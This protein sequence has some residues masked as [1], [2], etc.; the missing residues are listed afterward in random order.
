M[1]NFF[2]AVGGTGQNVALAYYRMTTLCGYE[3]S[4]I[5]VMDSDLSISTQ[6]PSFIPLEPIPVEPCILPLQRNSFRDLFNPTGDTVIDSVMSILFTSKEMRIPI[7]EGMF[8]RPS[9]GATTI[10]DK[11]LLMENDNT[12]KK[13]CQRSDA[14]LAN[15]LSTLQTEGDHSVV[16]C[17]S[18]MGGTGA[19][20]VPT[21]AQYIAR[22]VDKTKVKI[23]VLYSLRHFNILLP[24]QQ[25][26]YDEIKN[27]QLK[28][29]A[30]A[31]MCYL[32]G[33]INRGVD[34][35]VLFGL[36]EPFDV[37]YREAQRQAEEER[38]LYL[39]AAIM[40]SNSFHVNIMTLFPPSQDKI[41]T[42][43]IPYDANSNISNL[44]VSKIDVYLPNGISVGLDNIPK[45]A[46]SVIDFLDI[47]LK[48]IN[49]LPKYSLIPPLVVP[50]NLKHAIDDLVRNIQSNKKQ[51]CED[52][53]NS[54]RERR[55]TIESNLEWFKRLLRN[56]S[57]LANL[58]PKATVLSPQNGSEAIT[59]T[60]E[61]YEKTK[62]QPMGF[63]RDWVKNTNWNNPKTVEE[64]VKPL[65]IGLRKSI[66]KTFLNNIFGDMRF[67]A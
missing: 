42:Y 43:W 22:N 3:P 51:V 20:G 11:I 5:Y 7:D 34:A 49:P 67:T 50:N 58:K 31:G 59:L 66:N 37:P 9:V 38:F 52:I 41:Y 13:E 10:M 47:F 29:N 35:C 53:A 6:Q 18:A 12:Y 56:E 4:K 17:G 63:I 32:A 36:L 33:E 54:I 45:L 46:G 21:L 27:T 1:A 64:F 24:E 61:D 8:G 48:Y 25:L 62:N 26:Q 55:T 14:N 57:D 15:L 60:E 19:G 30:E 40:G 39:L 44:M 23:I 28:V 65:V 16:I 2:I